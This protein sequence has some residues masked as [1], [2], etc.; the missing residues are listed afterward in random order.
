[1]V[2]FTDA[3]LARQKIVERTE[4]LDGV[5]EISLGELVERYGAHSHLYVEHYYDYSDS[6]TSIYIRHYRE[7]TDEEY[8]ARLVK[9]R[10]QK[11]K[12]AARRAKDKE[13]KKA[14]ALAQ[15]EKDRKVFEK[16][17]SKYG[18]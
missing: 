1:M 10:V 15:E 4:S 17:Q 11:E 7:E 16:M 13:R 2:K 6:Y 14:Q 18:W 5:E 12:A 3:E 9:L 8:E